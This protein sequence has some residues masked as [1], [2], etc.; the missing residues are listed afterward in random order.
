[1]KRYLFII[2]SMVF[3]FSF[4]AILLS[5]PRVWNFEGS[6]D[7]W[8]GY[9]GGIIGA[10]FGVV[11]AYFVMSEQLKREEKERKRDN[12]PLI[13]PGSSERYNLT[14]FHGKTISKS[15]RD[16]KDIKYFTDLSFQLINGGKTPIFDLEYYYEF[17]NEDELAKSFTKE[18][19]LK[20]TYPHLWFKEDDQFPKQNYSLVHVHVRKD[21]TGNKTSILNEEEV[22]SYT[23]FESV[24]MPGQTLP[25][26][27]DKKTNMIFSFIFQ[28]FPWL[29]DAESYEWPLVKVK[30][31]YKDYELVQRKLSFNLMIDD[32]FVKDDK[33]DIKIKVDLKSIENSIF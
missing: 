11:G 16:F 28:S 24:L 5:I 9:W 1:M 25:M 22:V 30:V 33:L 23:Y 2:L 32:Y 26:Y 4:G 10:F 20:D 21:K 27:I 7:G 12:E 15:P 3:M 31:R 29:I 6:P 18:K 14:L 8:L 13:V 19:N 17:V